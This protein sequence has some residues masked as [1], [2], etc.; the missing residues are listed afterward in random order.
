MRFSFKCQFPSWLPWRTFKMRLH[1]SR[2]PDGGG[3]VR[4]LRVGGKL[5]FAWLW[6]LAAVPGEGTVGAARRTGWIK[7]QRG[8]GAKGSLRG[9]LQRGWEPEPG[10]SKTKNAEKIS[11]SG[12]WQKMSPGRWVIFTNRRKGGAE[13]AR[14]RAKIPLGG[15]AQPGSPRRWPLHTA[16]KPGSGTFPKT[17][18]GHLGENKFSCS[19]LFL[20][21]S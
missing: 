8:L 20:P 17:A 14:H 11:P 2:F 12:F 6:A 7:V 16:P 3:T 5:R 10:T 19:G 18:P 9:P 15:A 1:P 4:G 13:Q 21:S